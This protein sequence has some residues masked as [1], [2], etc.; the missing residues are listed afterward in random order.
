M[1]NYKYYIPFYGIYL[2]YKVEL[3]SWIY[4][5]CQ[6]VHAIYFGFMAGLIHVIVTW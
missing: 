5:T 6:G 1:K 3:D 4:G 2:F